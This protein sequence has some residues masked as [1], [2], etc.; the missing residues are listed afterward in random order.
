MKGLAFRVEHGRDR[1]AAALADDNHHL[2]LAA[3]VAGVAAVKSIGLHVGGLHVAAEISPINLS[4]LAFTAD[5]PPVCTENLIRVDEAMES[6]KLA[7]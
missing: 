6:P 4:N 7:E 3:L 5:N 1:I 2:A